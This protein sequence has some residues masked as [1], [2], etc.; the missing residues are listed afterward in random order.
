MLIILEGPDGAG[1]STLAQRLVTQLA[2]KYPD[3]TVELLHRGPPTSHPLDEYVVPL[4]DYRPGAGRH[5][6]CDRWHW[7]ELVYPR[8]LGRPTKMDRAV[9]DYVETFL[10]GR[11]AATFHIIA[12]L[13]VLT[14]RIV[15][16]GDDLVRIDQLKHIA[17]EFNRVATE[18]FTYRSLE[19]LTP[20]H[21]IWSAS[22]AESEA[23]D[24]HNDVT[25]IGGRPTQVLVYGDVR[26]CPGFTCHH[27]VRHHGVGT[28]FMPYPG[29]SGHYLF[30]ALGLRPYWSFTNA[31]DVDDPAATWWQLGCPH[32]IALGVNAHKKLTE[33]DVPHAVVPHPQY[34]RRFHHAAAADYGRLIRA[35][36]SSDRN[37]LKWRPSPRVPVSASTP[38]SS[39]T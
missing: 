28:A 5:I 23:N 30:R 21:I 17:Y 25:T 19:R 8:V 36:V 2:V 7:G 11:G 29:T 32:A 16:R 18:T 1:K 3:D 27:S 39:G 12:D 31:C 26:A 33:V 4:L 6:V 14:K 34:V 15:A 35:V 9:F 37:E 13:G 10:H 38:T 24:D 22:R 20:D